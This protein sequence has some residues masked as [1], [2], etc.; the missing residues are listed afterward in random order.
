VLT[1]PASH[2]C[3]LLFAAARG[4]QEGA[5]SASLFPHHEG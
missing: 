1:G 3:R 2:A 4:V 5:R